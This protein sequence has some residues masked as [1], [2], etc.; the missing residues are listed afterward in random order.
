MV[1][2]CN[3]DDYWGQFL[4]IVSFSSKKAK[5]NNSVSL[6]Y[7]WFLN[8]TGRDPWDLQIFI[9]SRW[10]VPSKYLKDAH[11]LHITTFNISS[12]QNCWGLKCHWAIELVAPS[13]SWNSSKFQSEAAISVLGD[14]VWVACFRREFQNRWSMTTNM[15]HGH[16]EFISIDQ[17]DAGDGWHNLTQAACERGSFEALTPTKG[18]D[19]IVA[20][21]IHFSVLVGCPGR[22]V[23]SC[24]TFNTHHLKFWWESW[25]TILPSVSKCSWSHW[26]CVSIDITNFRADTDYLLTFDL[27]KSVLDNER[28]VVGKLTVRLRIE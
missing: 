17:I 9:G 24:F 7:N 5:R 20:F 8:L 28:P 14:S 13:Q 22:N 2:S 15:M 1:F 23:P 26:T 12:S 16:E 6:R 18:W 19:F 21:S 27:H 10:T 4:M 11:N 25:I 3:N